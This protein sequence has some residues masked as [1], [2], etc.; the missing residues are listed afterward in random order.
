VAVQPGERAKFSI[1]SDGNG[2][3]TLFEE[4]SMADCG[5]SSA[6]TQAWFNESEAIS[7]Q[8]ANLTGEEQYFI[9]SLGFSFAC[10]SYDM[11]IELSEDSCSGLVDGG[12]T[13]N[14]ECSTAAPL[15][16]GS[17]PGQFIFN[18]TSDYYTV[19]LQPGELVSFDTMAPRT[20]GARVRSQVAASCNSPELVGH[21]IPIFLLGFVIRT[22]I[23]NRSDTVQT[24]TVEVFYVPD[25]ADPFGFC[26]DYDLE[27]SSEMNPLGIFEGDAFEPND[28]CE[29]HAPIT[30]GVY[31][32]TK[33]L[34]NGD[35][36]SVVVEPGET[37]SYRVTSPGGYL[38]SHLFDA[39]PEAG[40]AAIDVAVPMSN[41]LPG[42]SLDWTNTTSTQQDLSFFVLAKAADGSFATTYK[43]YMGDVVGE[44]FC[45]ST[46]NSTGAAG[47]ITGTGSTNVNQGNLRLSAS[48]LPNNTFGLIFFS[49]NEV[50]PTPFG[51]GMRC[52]GAPFYRLPVGNSGGNGTLSTL[53]NW[54]N[55]GSAGVIT[56]GS[57]WSFQAWFRDTA[58]GGAQF[59]LSDAMRI[60]M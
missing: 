57:T 9:F 19:V 24:Y 8:W 35:W 51:N 38:V 59:D 39:C 41:G 34:V 21:S 48:N 58:G 54:S 55:P 5:F 50:Q 47:E 27:I 11:E 10:T 45:S 20:P 29:T 12:F 33:D 18:G 52:L 32:L 60:E 36:Y 2:F 26:S 15:T 7:L 30:D 6:L 49:E 53:I 28:T 43:L 4:G 23:F 56:N 13:G 40:G 17:Y 3:I 25:P 1:V 16:P 37:L 31:S 22:Y 42:I 46:A 14:Q 44:V